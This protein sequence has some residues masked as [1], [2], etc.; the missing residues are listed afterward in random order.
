[1]GKMAIILELAGDP[2]CE[3][4]KKCGKYFFTSPVSILQHIQI[5]LTLAKKKKI[6]Q[7][8]IF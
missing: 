6:M 5:L 4:K 2:L 1:M 3:R 7:P 8:L